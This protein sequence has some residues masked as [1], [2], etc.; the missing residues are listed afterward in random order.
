MAVSL[1]QAGEPAGAV[2]GLKID[3]SGLRLTASPDPA[4]PITLAFHLDGPPR[5]PVEFEVMI[6]GRDASGRTF[7]GDPLESPRT[8]PF[9]LELRGTGARSKASPRPRPSKP[10]VLVW[11][12]MPQFKGRTA[13][14]LNEST[15]R[16]LKALGYIQ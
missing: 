7:I 13:I 16:E 3:S 6:D 10:Y 11:H 5:L 14:K 4:R 1:D 15:R 12:N 8:M 9:A 2:P